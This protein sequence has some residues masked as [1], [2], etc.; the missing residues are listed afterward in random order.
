MRVDK[1]F[2][3]AITLLRFPLAVLVVYIH[4]QGGPIHFQSIENAEFSYI[5]IYDLLR[6]WLSGI[7]ASIAVPC[8]FFIS[9]YLF[10][11]SFQ[12]EWNSIKWLSKIKKR[13]STICVPYLLWNIIYICYIII[14]KIIKGIQYGDYSAIYEYFKE[15][16]WLHLLW[17]CRTFG[18]NNIN[19]FGHH[20]FYT[21]PALSPLW[22]LRD[23]M[24]VFLLTPIIFYLIKKFS[25]YPLILFGLAYVS[26]VWPDISGFSAS[27]IF[28][29]S[30]GAFFSLTS[31]NIVAFLYK[32]RPYT[33]Y[34]FLFL[35]IICALLGGGSTIRGNILLPFCSIVGTLSAFICALYFCNKE[36]PHIHFLS[37]SSFFYLCIPLYYNKYF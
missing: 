8:F 20:V 33:I 23:L 1:D 7:V 4:C 31:N 16:G 10:F 3:A 32:L 34:I 2:S 25:F 30:F 12:E 24:V 17:D 9:G 15:Q 11:I 5:D 18:E 28:Y 19:W 35:S 36:V 37:G 14:L 13:V 26:R 6:I 27:S 29:F 21:A 22:F